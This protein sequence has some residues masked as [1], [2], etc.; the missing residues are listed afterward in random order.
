M[1]RQ[2]TQA[3]Q[4]FDAAGGALVSPWERSKIHT[5]GTEQRREFQAGEKVQRWER[6]LAVQ[7]REAECVP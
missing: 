1:G 5:G 2:G 6:T 7:K 3:D 4:I